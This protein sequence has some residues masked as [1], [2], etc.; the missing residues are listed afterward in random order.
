[1]GKNVNAPP[2]QITIKSLTF[3]QLEIEMVLLVVLWIQKRSYSI[4]Y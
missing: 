4:V 1:M 3:C 2:K